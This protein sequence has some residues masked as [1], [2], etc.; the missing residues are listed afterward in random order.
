MLGHGFEIGR[1][2]SDLPRVPTGGPDLL[3]IAGGAAGAQVRV[4]CARWES[5]DEP[6]GAEKIVWHDVA[7]PRGASVVLDTTLLP[8][9]LDIG[10]TDLP[11]GENGRFQQ[12]HGFRTGLCGPC[13]GTPRCEDIVASDGRIVVALPDSLWDEG[14]GAHV[15]ISGVW[16]G[17]LEGAGNS[18]EPSTWSGIWR[19]HRIG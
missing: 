2:A 8:T 4:P 13:R 12:G 7:L 3:L 17:R 15:T 1:P 18:P 9:R 5:Y 19:V 10:W 6:S 14:V 16:F 11:L